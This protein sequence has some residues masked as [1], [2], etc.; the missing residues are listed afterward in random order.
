MAIRPA[1]CDK[2]R[3]KQQGKPCPAPGCPGILEVKPCRYGLVK[4]YDHK[5][6]QNTTMFLTLL[7]NQLKHITRLA[8]VPLA[9]RGYETKRYEGDSKVT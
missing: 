4:N 1:I 6:V 2:A 7:V 9:S 5:F 3:R 8:A